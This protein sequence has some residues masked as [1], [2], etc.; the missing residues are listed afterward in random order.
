VNVKL[1]FKEEYQDVFGIA[2]MLGGDPYLW[3]LVYYQNQDLF[4]N[5]HLDLAPGTELNIFIPDRRKRLVVPPRRLYS[6]SLGVGASRLGQTV[7]QVA[8]T[9]LGHQALAHYLRE[10]E[11]NDIPESGWLQTGQALYLPA[12]VRMDVAK[13]YHRRLLTRR[14]VRLV[15][16]RTS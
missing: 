5:D 1:T 12:L 4:G 6:G 13:Q 7:Q 9:E 8:Q 15:M 14:D 10:E 2:L 3:D 16:D 11:G